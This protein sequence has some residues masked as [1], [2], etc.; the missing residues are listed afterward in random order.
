MGLLFKHLSQQHLEKLQQIRE[1]LERTFDLRHSIDNGTPATL[2][3]YWLVSSREKN[4]L[5]YEVGLQQWHGEA[6]TK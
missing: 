4:I 5:R 6:R 1:E 2:K 3:N